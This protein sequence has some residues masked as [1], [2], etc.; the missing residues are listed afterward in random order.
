TY[1]GLAHS[2]LLS[3]DSEAVKDVKFTYVGAVY[4]TVSEAV[5][6]DTY[7]VTVVITFNDNYNA[8]GLSGYNAAT[9]EL[10]LTGT[11]VIGKANLTVTA[12]NGSVEYGKAAEEYGYDISGF[13]NGESKNDVAVIEITNVTYGY[14]TGKNV[15]GTNAGKY[16]DE[17]TVNL[18][19]TSAN[20]T[21]NYATVGGTLTVTPKVIDSAGVIWYDKDG[22]TAGTQ[23]TYKFDGENHAP[24]AVYVPDSS[25]TLIVSGAQSTAGD[26]YTATVT[27]IG[28]ANSANYALPVVDI[29]VSFSITNE[30]VVEYQV[31]WDNTTHVYDGKAYKPTAYYYDGNT[32]IDISANDIT[33][34]GGN[35]VNAGT[36][37]ASVSSNLNGRTLTNTSMSF[38]I[39]KRAVYI[40]ISDSKSHYGETPNMGA[41]SWKYVYLD[42]EKQFLA[43]EKYTI[44]FT[45]EATSTSPI[46]TYPISGHFVAVNAKNYDVIFVGSYVS[47]SASLNGKF[48]TLAIGK[49]SYDMT[50]VTF[51]G[52]EV[53][54]DGAAHGITLSGLPVGLT[55][56]N[57]EC[58]Y[59]S[60]K[61][62]KVTSAINADVYNVTVNFKGL[63]TVNYE[64]VESLTTTL[65]IKKAA[66]VITANDNTVVYGDEP[67]AN[68]VT[69][70]GFA[71]AAGTEDESVLKGQLVFT[72]NYTKGDSA[73]TYRIT[74]SG[75]TSDNYEISFR[76]G[77]LTVDKRTVTVKWYYD[78]TRGDQ[79][80]QYTYDNGKL[81]APV[82]VAENLLAGDSAEITVSGAQG[83]VGVNITATA[84]SISNS[85]YKLPTDGSETVKFSIMPTR[86]N[87]VIWD[88]SEF[89]YDGNAHKPT[90]FYLDSEGNKVDIGGQYISVD[91]G[92]AIDAK[93]G[94]Y[95]AEIDNTYYNGNNLVGD[96]QF[97]FYIRSLE[98]T[99]EINA[100]TAVYGNVTVA[101]N[102]WN[103]GA[104]SNKF[105]DGSRNP[106]SAGTALEYLVFAAEVGNVT[107]VGTYAITLVCSDSN[108]KVTFKNGSITINKATV[109]MNGAV[110]SVFDNGTTASA[111]NTYEFDGQTHGIEITGTLPAGITGVSY[112]YYQG[113]NLVST[114][115]VREAGSYTVKAIFTV[116]GNYEE[117]TAEYT[118]ILT[119]TNAEI[120][121]DNVTFEAAKSVVYSGEDQQVFVKG[122]AVGVE[123]VEYDYYTFDENATENLGVKLSGLPKNVGRYVVVA[124]FV[125]AENYASNN[126]HKTM[127]LEITRAPLTVII[128]N[129]T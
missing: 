87:Y 5:N 22:G 49:A 30:P 59:S 121:I 48:G 82:A 119:I 9:G 66:L 4:G 8:N 45:C 24:V 129:K 110:T 78:S 109:V 79:P 27:G 85:N 61:G 73:G 107:P 34:E 16:E 20:Y 117:I 57:Y 92:N 23:F 68:G 113:G 103:Y 97:R 69:Y 44:N 60:S 81:F 86:N 37:N 62:W 101:Q 111:A 90:A 128:N 100:Q 35:A 89:I 32:K 99:V 72:Y 11:L 77:T 18:T 105:L 83:D 2:L 41:V 33:V 112:E 40:E 123:R 76:A 39:S 53:T 125:A 29:K 3:G 42:T 15:A 75:L 55:A 116:D 84:S 120:D 74:P 70:T 14:R 127:V 71:T 19:Y 88:N 38:G 63:D 65:T 31:I 54:Y 108:Y 122:T 7:S 43:G 26:K 124:K 115:G 126:A 98:V 47:E 10:T 64:P 118:A 50:K 1:D 25:V 94:Y 28:G 96:R 95:L 46:G 21:V 56:A 80:L 36:Y 106:I 17:I 67:S 93:D 58:I 6:A 51:V 104:G 91:V 12:K 114:N 52:T 102:L 13:V